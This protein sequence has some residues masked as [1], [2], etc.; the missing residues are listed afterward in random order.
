MSGACRTR[1]AL[2]LLGFALM[3]TSACSRDRGPG[4]SSSSA[5]A[6][7]TI[8][9]INKIATDL[10]TG[11]SGTD[12]RAACS[13]AAARLDQMGSPDKLASVAAELDDQL[14]E[15]ALDQQA[16]ISSVMAACRGQAPISVVEAAAELNEADRVLGILLTRERAGNE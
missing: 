4:T 7:Q 6:H 13:A 14:A 10:S 16:A 15:A 11:A 1:I 12:P 3:A 5:A 8:H 2:M 9:R